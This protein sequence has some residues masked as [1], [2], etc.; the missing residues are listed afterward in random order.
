VAG[1]PGPL[2]EADSR[3]QVAEGLGSQQARSTC[4]PK[5]VWAHIRTTTLSR[6]SGEAFRI[7]LPVCRIEALHGS[8][9]F[10][11]LSSRVFG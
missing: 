10:P 8:R 3:P 4:K 6:W 9:Q 7:S 2:E 1:R 5:G 11:S